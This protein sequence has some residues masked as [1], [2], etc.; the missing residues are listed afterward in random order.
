MLVKRCDMIF[1]LELVSAKLSPIS[2]FLLHGEQ[3]R[4]LIH[5]AIY[6]VY[7]FVLH[8]IVHI[9]IKTRSMGVK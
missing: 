7:Y 8:L 2:F 6:V 3:L 9:V 1:L 4:E 5:C